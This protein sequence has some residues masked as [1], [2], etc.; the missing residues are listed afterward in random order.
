MYMRKVELRTMELNKYEVIKKL[1]DTNGNKNSA[2]IKL[3][4]S[5]RNLNRLIAKY[6]SQGKKGFIHGNRDRKPTIATSDIL[7]AKII[8]LYA[9][10][11][12]DANIKHFCEL[13]VE[14]ENIN[15][16]TTTIHKWLHEIN[17]YSPKANRV[18][19]SRI[20]KRI[21]K[22]NKKKLSDSE[23]ENIDLASQPLDRSLAHPRHPRAKY[24]GELIQMDASSLKWFGDEITHLHLAIDDATGT[25]VGA[26]F[27][28]KETL[29]GYYNVLKQILSN[30]GI[31][32]KLLTDRRTVFEYKKLNS[33]SYEKDTTTQF[34]Y[35][36]SILGINIETTSVPQ[37]KGR[38]ERLNQTLQ[39]RLP[40][41]LRLANINRIDEANE[42]L[43]SYIKK[44]NE[45][46]AIQLD[47]N[48]NAYEKQMDSESINKV[49]SVLSKRV[50]DAGHSIKYEN[51]YYEVLDSESKPVYFSKG[52]KALVI[53]CLDNSLY[54]NVNDNIYALNRIPSH[55]KHSKELDFEKPEKVKKIYIPSINHPWKRQSFDKHLEK[56][57][58]R[59]IGANV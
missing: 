11:Y 29:F 57:K 41:V 46:H 7:K 20:N 45:T 19:K 58:H 35:A 21:K 9:N 27:D 52:T 28:T 12:R 16:S 55:F 15:I 17:L 43:T 51:F 50:I 14:H 54:V 4:C 32:V 49:L 2:I 56:Q 44:Y 53:K 23:V 13:L 42:F 3:G 31:P 38:V 39:S 40:I 47:D 5:S 10:K 26:F 25:I 18:T 36:C 6:K 30:Q 24:A 8:D 48:K 22:L 33:D 1:V 34:S 37:G 59:Q